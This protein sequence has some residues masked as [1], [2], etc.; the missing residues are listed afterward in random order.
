MLKDKLARGLRVLTDT[1]YRQFYASQ[2]QIRSISSRERRCSKNALVRV[3]IRGK[4]VGLIVG[5]RVVFY[6]LRPMGW[7]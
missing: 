2:Q 1:R 7:L 3:P 4:C 5:R 6:G